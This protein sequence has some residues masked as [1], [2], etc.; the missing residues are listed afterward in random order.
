MKSK[1]VSPAAIVALK[2]ALTDLYWYKN[3]LRSF[4][5]TN[6]SNASLLSRIDWNAYKRSIVSEVVDFLVKNQTAMQADLVRL[7]EEV[8]K[9]TDFSH[10]ERL[11]GGK[12]KATLARKSVDA[13][14]TLFV[15]HAEIEADEEKAA[16]RRQKA[17]DNLKKSSAVRS[18]LDELSKKYLLLLTDANP[19]QRGFDLEKIVCQLFALFDLDPKASFRIQGEQIDG[20]F[21]F[22]GTEYLFEAKWQKEQI[23]A[24]DLDG[25]AKKI[26]RK[27][28]NTLGLYLSMNG[29]SSDG[30]A[31]H[32]SGRRVIL[33]IDGG[34]LMAVL[35]GRIELPQLL[36]RIKRNAAQTGNIYLGLGEILQVRDK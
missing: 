19:Q 6:L 1:V 7:V 23:A 33:L 13:L 5:T 31:A 20:A 26:E 18:A 2:Q 10:L 16:A 35:E 11:D 12:A 34:H 4:L 24:H 22:D 9:V 17:A 29:Y 27:L 15:V 32:S 14:R 36:T 8:S 3:D 30:I 21:S 28:D 25:F